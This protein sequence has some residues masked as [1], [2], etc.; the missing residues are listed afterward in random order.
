MAL[1][2]GDTLL[3][4][5]YRI[6]SLL[7]R[8]GFGFVYQAEDKHLNE[9]VA[10]KELFPALIGDEAILK[11]FLAE[12]KA[13]LRLTH[14][15]I[16]RTYHVFEEG[17]N[18]YIVMECMAG[19]SLEARL[20][21]QGHLPVQEAV[22]IA[23]EVCEG[24]RYAHQRG[25][26]HCDLKPANILFDKRGGAKVADF[27]VAHVSEQTLSRSWQTPA[28][29]VAGTLPYMSPEQVDGVREDPRVDVYALGAVLYRMLTG[30][31]YLAFD[32]R[33]TPRAQVENVQRICSEQPQPPSAHRR[34]LPAWLDG[35]VLKALA[36]QPEQRY[37]TADDLQAALLQRE[38]AAATI[39][40]SR[41]GPRGGEPQ[42]P[43][44]PA[45]RRA[46]LPALFWPLLGGA[47]VLLLVLVIAGMAF[48]GGG[49]DDS[50]AAVT[51]RVAVA[52]LASSP[53]SAPGLTKTPRPTF[54]VTLPPTAPIPTATPSAT[55]TRALP[56]ATEP[57][58]NTPTGAPTHTPAPTWTPTAVPTS[59]PTSTRAPRPTPTATS[60]APA[61]TA[62]APTR[63]RPTATRVPATAGQQLPAPGL[64]GP[65]E[66]Q[67]FSENDEVILQWQPVGQLPADGY[68]VVTLAY[69]H[70]GATWTDETP[71]TKKTQWTVSEHRYLLDLSDDGLYRWSV[72]VMRQTGTDAGGRPA[73]TPLSPA[74]TG[75]TFTW[76]R[77]E[78]GD[79]GGGTPTR[80]PP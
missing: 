10:I 36:K 29:F 42:P 30:R 27:G 74:S 18:Y 65:P 4:G 12:A 33:E 47:A 8:G 14:E 2:P 64:V 76:R 26:V 80:E 32:A 55:A 45:T 58:T 7:G 5:Q 22:R 61:P 3:N 60:T 69:S 15:R 71:W 49:G 48:F 20:Q 23:A 37:A 77:S 1:K 35:V 62:A 73:G 52:T 28:G 25:V 31:T 53:T 72:R 34:R 13:T 39:P 54:T 66:G 6:L 50:T 78:G 43:P 57:A 59:I 19:G 11:R 63:P 68:Y 46:P 9:Q 51:P 40:P 24:L 21:R 38:R 70:Q 79:G 16:V 17:D 56:P 67:A 41:G 75:R 44:P